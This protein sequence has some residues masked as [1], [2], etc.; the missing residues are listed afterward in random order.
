MSTFEGLLFGHLL[1]V[2]VW[3]GGAAMLQVFAIRATLAGPERV[4]QFAG[5]VEWIGSRILSPASGLVVLFGVLL[6]LTED[7][8]GFSQAWIWLALVMFAVSAATGAAF[9]GP[10]SGRINRIA[11]REGP[12]SPEV[13]RRVKRV[14]AIARIDLLL[15]VLIILDMVVK[16]GF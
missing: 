13:G 16:P 4:A 9:L 8:F 10:E 15:L 11:A 12:A 7:A 2:A 3:V 14:V 1:A 5:D 6:V